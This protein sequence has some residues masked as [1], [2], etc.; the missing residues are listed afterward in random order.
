MEQSFKDLFS[1]Q[2]E[3]YARFRP[4]YPQALFQY[5]ASLVNDHHLAWDCGCGNGQAA[6]GLVRYFSQV[7]AT[8]PSINQLKKTSGHSRILYLASTAE[9]VPF[10]GRKISLVTVAQAAHW[11]K[12]D[13]FYSEVKRVCIPQR[14]IL[15]LWCYG[16]AKISPEVDHV[17]NYYYHGLESYWEP[18][19]KFVE[20]MYTTIPFPFQEVVPPSISMEMEWDLF[21]LTGYLNTWSATQ[22]IRK[23]TGKNPVDEIIPELRRTWM[24]PPDRKK[25]VTWPLGL[26]IGKV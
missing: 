20:E 26:R 22:A 12:L 9:A 15:A 14:S 11:F 25:R 2:S 24:G 10:S 16:L 5:L 17:V 6:V 3:E 13:H 18:E 23:G 8:D 19:R 1:K 4:S 21:D 7:V